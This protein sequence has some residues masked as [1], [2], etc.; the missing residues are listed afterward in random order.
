MATTLHVCTTCRG[1]V[2]AEAGEVRPG[3]L[4]HEALTAL[5]CP[6]GVVVSPVE[7]LSACTQGCAIAL[8]GPGKWSYVF[9]RLDP[10]D[11]ETILSGAAQFEAADKGLIPWRERPDIFRKQC[12]AR[13]P[14]QNVPPQ[15]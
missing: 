5:T 7:C 8:S 2:A 6:E 3:A 15:E 9:G 14:P 11:A 12:L 13:I 4:L 10:R 1:T